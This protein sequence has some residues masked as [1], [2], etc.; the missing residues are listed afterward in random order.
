ME[1]HPYSYGTKLTG[2]ILHLF[3]TVV[4]TIAVFLLASMLSKNIF[5]LSDVGTEQFLDSGY[6]TKCIEKKCDDLSDYLRLLIK[7]ESR[8]SEENRRYLQYTNEFKSG[9]SNFCYWYR[10]GEAWYTNQPDTKE[11]QEFDVEAVLMEAKTMGNYLIYDLVD[12]EFGT[13]I[14]GMA[15]YFFGGGNQM[16]WPADD[17]TLIIGIDTE[18]SAEDDIYEASRE[19]EQLHPWIKVCIFCGLVSLMGWIISLVYLT[20]ATGRRTEEEKIHLN[21]ID[22]IKTEILVAA[23]IFMMVELVILITKVNSEEWAV[24]GII[25]ASGTVSLV[26]DGLFLIFYL[27]MV[28]RMKAEMLWETSVACWLERGIRKV[29]ARQKTTVRVL[30]LFAGHMAVCFILAVGA[31]YYRSMTALVLLLLFSAGECYMILRK[32]V[33]QYQI[34]LGV[35]KI[36]DGALS[37]KIDIEQL[38]GEEKS[39]AEAINN[40]G[41]GLLHAVDDSTKNERMKA[42]LITNVSHDIK[43]PLTSIINYVNL[44]KLEKIDNERVQGYIKILDEKSQ[45]LKQLTA[46]LVEASKISSGNVKLDMQV[47]DLV[48]L[49]Y[50]T[51]GE[52]NEK[53]EQKELTIVTKLPKTA[54]LI[55]ADGRQLYRVIENL[56]NNVA[57]YA[58]EKTR[59]YVDI[60][61]VEE[62]VV[63]SIK[64]VSEHS[65][66]RE[67][68]NAGDLTERFIRGDSSRTTEGSGLGLSIAKSLTVLMGGVFDIKVDG[69]LFKASITFPQ[70]ADENGSNP[71]MEEPASE[72]DYEIEELE[73]EE[74]TE[75]E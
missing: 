11:G 56:Y 19:Y 64:N 58:L 37:G 75:K 43:T 6:Y 70:Y 52:F 62:K 26:I 49:V 72:D 55:R 4:L 28:R 25:V 15:D 67:N 50:Q 66:A 42:D 48:E 13:D 18:L 32:A 41:E 24:Y 3:F 30:L 45:R 16:L 22:K 9:E 34:R 53:F 40:I 35:E 2:L 14:N 12:K 73:P 63:F 44:M 8:T 21:P 60:A 61:Y 7:G 1:S 71:K 74:R 47:I 27:S 38:H 65:L 17:M 5:E 31:F 33:E 36:R 23:F 57:K 46:D 69:D 51:S 59:V 29:F 20:L 10:I 39:L 68:S 54:V